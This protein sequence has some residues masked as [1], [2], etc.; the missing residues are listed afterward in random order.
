MY[1]LSKLDSIYPYFCIPNIAEFRQYRA[2]IE[3]ILGVIDHKQCGIFVI[4][5][6]FFVADVKYKILQSFLGTCIL[7]TI[8]VIVIES[9]ASSSTEIPLA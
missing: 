8:V 1:L 2:S 9:L 5:G 4:A 3:I 6:L 7:P